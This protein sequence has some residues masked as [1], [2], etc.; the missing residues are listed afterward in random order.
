MNTFEVVG[1]SNIALVKYWGKK[2]KQ[3]PINPS[4]SFT[5]KNAQ[6]ILT[7]DIEKSSGS[8]LI[9]KFEGKSEAGFSKKSVIAWRMFC[10]L[11][12]ILNNYK[13]E[14]DSTNTFPHSTGIASS[15]SSQMGLA[16]IA[17]ELIA[18]VKF[19]YFSETD[20]KI[21]SSLARLAS[22]S[23]CRSINAGYN[24]W[25]K[26][27]LIPGSSDEYAISI[28]DINP[29]FKDLQDT[30]LVISSHPKKI[31]SSIGHSLMENHPYKTT[32][33]E[34]AHKNLKSILESLK[35]GDFQL[36]SQIVEAEA[37]SLHA[38]MM[39]SNPSFIL[40]EPKTLEVINLIQDFKKDSGL[41]LTF[42]LDAGPNIHLLYPSSIKAK[43]DTFIKRELSPLCVSEVGILDDEVWIK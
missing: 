33:I 42:T 24:L 1:H 25:G 21:C 19:E 8:E 30:I 43:M 39:T 18:N 37:M 26:T 7:V 29:I 17:T 11:Y 3:L 22:G 6:S 4:L 41:P 32:R 9:Y 28:Q 40:F 38:M 27:D 15:A 36:F 23:A 5:L 2:G 35:T 13:I 31:S 10:E 20:K 14:I 16:I 12:P 34:E